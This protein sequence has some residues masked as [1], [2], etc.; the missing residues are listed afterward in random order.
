MEQQSATLK[1][2]P[3]HSRH[4]AAGAKMVPFAG[5]EM[6]LEYAGIEEEH[7][8]VRE[9]AGL[10]DVSHMGRIILSGP[11]TA[12]FIGRVFTG[13]VDSMKIGDLLYGFLLNPEGCIIDDVVVGKSGDSMFYIVVN[14]SNADKALDWLNSNRGKDKTFCIRATDLYMQIAL[15]GPES[16]E[17]LSEV[18][19]LDL[20]GLGFYK[21]ILPRFGGNEMLICRSGYTG[22]DGFELY[23]VPEVIIPLW[24]ALLATGRVSPCGLGCRDTLRFEAGLPLYGNE[25]SE[26]ITPVEASLSSFV[27]L[28]KARDF[29][30]REAVA[31]RK[32][33]G[34]RRKLVGLELHGPGIA[35]H[36]Y[37]VVDAE[38][39][40][41][42]TV[43]TG[44]LSPTLG[45][46][47]A[48]AMV[49][50]DLA[51]LGTEL[52]VQVRRRT[53]PATVVKKRFYTPRYKR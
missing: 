2:T 39:R 11:D 4:I 20:S 26:E 8:A 22:E 46:A 34:P 53:I 45:K 38:G 50:A 15:Q 12:A 27:K 43:T 48:M 21:S 42:G 17:I 14:A 31:A 30:G 52:A 23:A 1:T 16:E 19:G 10:F 28:D 3:L 18:T 51:T 44:Y 29:I 9:H 25:L 5:W 35:R 41:V 36:G 24:D 47:L 40:E 49:D 6:P 32:A 37:P 13:D 33:A 7:R